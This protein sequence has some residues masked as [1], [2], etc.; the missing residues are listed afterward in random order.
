MC[1]KTVVDV[2][3]H[4]VMLLACF[5]QRVDMDADVTEIAH[6]VEEAMASL[7]GDSMPLGHR[8][9]WGNRNTDFCPELMAHPAG[10][11]LCHRLYPW[12][13]RCSMPELGNHLRV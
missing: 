8:Q 13:V 2:V 3:S 9:L 1:R 6:M 5:I 4:A 10:L 11:D 12:D 7:Y